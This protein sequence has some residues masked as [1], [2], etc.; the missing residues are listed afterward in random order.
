MQRI[1]VYGGNCLSCKAVHNWVEERGKL[2]TDEE[3][4]TEVWKRLRQ[5]SKDFYCAGFDVLV[6]R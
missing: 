6:K 4:E 5:Q 3:V 2:F 1:H